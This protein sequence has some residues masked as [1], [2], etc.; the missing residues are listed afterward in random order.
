MTEYG[1]LENVHS[2]DLLVDWQGFA[3][4][5]RTSVKGK[6]RVLGWRDTKEESD[7]G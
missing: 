6:S 7:R 4:T 5:F 1:I 2:G 3:P